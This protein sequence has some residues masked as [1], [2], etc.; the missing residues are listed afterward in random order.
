MRSFHASMGSPKIYSK[1]E[2]AEVDNACDMRVAY[3]HASM[4]SPKIY[5]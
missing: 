4:K 5:S 1:Q 3:L 2:V